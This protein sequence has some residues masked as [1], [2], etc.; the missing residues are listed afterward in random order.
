[1]SRRLASW[2]LLSARSGT[3]SLWPCSLPIS[4]DLFRRWTLNPC[5][6]S[7][8]SCRIAGHAH[9]EM[10]AETVAVPSDTPNPT[11]PSFVLLSGRSRFDSWRGHGGGS[12]VV[13]LVLGSRASGLLEQRQGLAPPFPYLN[14]TFAPSAGLLHL[15]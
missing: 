5:L 14:M 4:A 9:A 7:A 10:T 11:A 12:L 3:R 2:R 8:Q 13:V 6:N 1:M 15:S